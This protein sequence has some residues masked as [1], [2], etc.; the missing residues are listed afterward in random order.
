MESLRS[1]SQQS[2]VAAAP[3]PVATRATLSIRLEQALERRSMT[4]VLR[5]LAGR[6]VI[7]QPQIYVVPPSLEGR[8]VR[9]RALAFPDAVASPPMA[10]F[11]AREAVADLGALGE[12]Q[13]SNAEQ[14]GKRRVDESISDSPRYSVVHGVLHFRGTFSTLSASGC[15]QGS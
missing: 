8:Q 11:H 1:G 15:F 13:G 2:L 9:E 7:A 6:I 4:S 10:E 5:R 12:R 3:L 14:C